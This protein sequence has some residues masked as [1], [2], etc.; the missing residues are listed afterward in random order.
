MASGGSAC[1]RTRWFNA[2]N[3]GEAGFGHAND[4]EPSFCTIG[5]LAIDNSFW[6]KSANHPLRRPEGEPRGTVAARFSGDDDPERGERSSD[7]S[8]FLG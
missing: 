8:Q 7:P 5:G 3:E 2:R 4:S 6:T 1:C